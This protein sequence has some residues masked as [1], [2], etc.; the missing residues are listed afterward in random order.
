MALNQNSENS[1]F[2]EAN[3][4][5]APLVLKIPK[6]YVKEIHKLTLN[7]I[8]KGKPAKIKRTTITSG[9]SQGGLRMLDFEVTNKALPKIAWIK[10]ITEHVHP[11]WKLIPEFAA[12]KTLRFIFSNRMSVRYQ[13]SV[14]ALIA[15]HLFTT[16]YKYWQEYIKYSYE[17]CKTL[18]KFARPL[19]KSTKFIQRVARKVRLKLQKL[20]KSQNSQDNKIY[21]IYSKDCKEGPSKVTRIV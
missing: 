4:S 6:S 16:G 21:E 8:W 13:T 5:V 2:V 1:R 20:R 3:L 17:N 14:S 18:L 15:F 10:R 11:A 19:I 12:A 7:S 9:V